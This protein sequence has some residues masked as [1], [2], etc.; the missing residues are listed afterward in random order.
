[1]CNLRV[2]CVE[3]NAIYG[4]F[5]VGRFLTLIR[6]I[7]SVSEDPGGQIKIEKKLIKK[8]HVLQS[9]MLSVEG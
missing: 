3:T 5:N 9:W 2:Y 7:Y 4:N 6:Q 8:F 1:M